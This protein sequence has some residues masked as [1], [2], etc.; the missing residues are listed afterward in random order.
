MKM[1]LTIS[2]PFNKH[3]VHIAWWNSHDFEPNIRIFS[4]SRSE[5]P[6]LPTQQVFNLPSLHGLI[7]LISY[8]NTLVCDLLNASYV[9]LLSSD[10]QYYRALALDQ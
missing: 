7:L 6:Y 1:F 3:L 5:G 10:I 9:T 8:W 4:K 2:S